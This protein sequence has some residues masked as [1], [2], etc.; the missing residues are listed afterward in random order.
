MYHLSTNPI[1]TGY[2]EPKYPKDC[3][4]N[5]SLE[6]P[7]KRI[8][9][10]P[11]IEQAL[12][13][14][15]FNIRSTFARMP[16]ITL[17]VYAPEVTSQTLFYSNDFL[18]R[19]VFDAWVTGEVGIRTKC[20]MI[21]IGSIRVLNPEGNPMFKAKPFNDESEVEY[22][23]SPRMSWS[24]CG[25]VKS[26]Q[27]PKIYQWENFT[28]SK[29]EFNMNATV[30]TTIDIPEGTEPHVK[31][32]IRQ[33]VRNLRGS[34]LDLETILQTHQTGRARKIEQFL[35]AL[36]RNLEPIR[37]VYADKPISFEMGLFTKIRLSVLQN[38]KD[39][40]EV[41]ISSGENSKSVSLTVGTDIAQHLSVPVLLRIII[42][43]L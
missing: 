14:I 42:L 9:V 29:E 38:S 8:C 7:L 1:L 41:T 25:L 12:W 11:T 5:N 36:W 28:L 30:N 43:G 24:Q 20:K 32:A 21:K 26:R 22:N 2:W 17:Y 27:I 15:Y 4:M 34:A 16:Y 6:P 23:I 19:Y 35:E 39:T 10:A 13:S 3:K 18:C 31:I 37:L 40:V 33:A